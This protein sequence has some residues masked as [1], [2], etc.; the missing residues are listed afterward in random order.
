VGQGRVPLQ[1]EG[2]GPQTGDPGAVG[3]DEACVGFDHRFLLLRDL[4]QGPLGY[5]SPGSF[6]ECPGPPHLCSM[7]AHVHDSCF[8]GTASHHQQL[9]T[10]PG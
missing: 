3:Q 5:G 2:T 6:G 9:E 8:E 10:K 7:D 4:R 1:G